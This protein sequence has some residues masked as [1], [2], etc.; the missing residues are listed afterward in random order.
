M[1]AEFLL[2]EF[3]GSVS[4]RLEEK[5]ACVALNYHYFSINKFIKGTEPLKLLIDSVIITT[6]KRS[7]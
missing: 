3:V 7:E 4:A 5:R 6:I 2:V 1:L